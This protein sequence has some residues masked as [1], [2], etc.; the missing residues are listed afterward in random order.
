MMDTMSM[1]SMAGSAFSTLATGYFWLVRNRREKP[2]L[3]AYVADREF[4]LGRG[5]AENRQV[6]CKLGLIVANYSILPNSLLGVALA[7]KRKDGGWQA[8][9]GMTF[10]P[11]TPLPFN[12]PPMQTVLLR[13]NGYLSFPNVAE[14]ESSASILPGY[15]E[16]HLADPRQYQVQ[17]RALNNRR[18]TQVVAAA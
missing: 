6:G 9:Q 18:Q 3:R 16:R 7:V 15:L 10:D 11:Q 14:L 17:L 1:F 13:M 12:I 2:N 5:G 8:V 4:Y